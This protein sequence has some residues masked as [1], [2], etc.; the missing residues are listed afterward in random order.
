MV[1]LVKHHPWNHLSETELE[2][3]SGFRTTR[4]AKPPL[5]IG[6]EMQLNTL[7]VLAIAM[8]ALFGVLAGSHKHDDI[9][10]SE[11]IL[12]ELRGVQINCA[13]LQRDR[14]RGRAEMVRDLRA[15][16]ITREA[17][18]K[19]LTV[20]QHLFERAPHDNAENLSRLFKQLKE[21]VE[22]TNLE[23]S[24]SA[25]HIA[26]LQDSLSSFVRSVATLPWT[27]SDRLK[28][29]TLVLQF[30]A[31]PSASLASQI[32]QYLTRLSPSENLDSRQVFRTGRIVLS[33]LPRLA[34]S[35]S[36][37]AS[38]D[39]IAKATELEQEY[40]KSYSL[41]GANVQRTRVICA[42]VCL[43]LG[44][45]GFV[46]AHRCRT[47]TN[48]LTRR[49]E[50]EAA[51][52]EIEA[53]FGS[54]RATKA[55]VNSSTE[56]ALR[57]IQRVFNADQC[58]LAVVSAR[59]K[60][61]DSECFV[62]NT[63]MPVSN[64][65][66]IDLAA[67]LIDPEEPAFRVVSAQQVLQAGI[68][69]V[70]QI[71][72]CKVYDEQIAVCCLVYEE[73]RQLPVA[74]ELQ[75]L[76]RVTVSVCNHL[77]LQRMRSESE[78]VARRL[79]HAERLRSVGTIASGIAHEFNNIL[80][81]ILGYAEMAQSL[82]RRP[83]KPRSYISQIILA[84]NRA[85]LM[86]EQIL[87][88]SRERKRSTRPFDV[89][90]VVLDLVPL[91]RVT[92]GAEFQLEVKIREWQTVIE[93]SP[94]DIH[95]ILLN[96]CKNSS[97]AFSNGGRIEIALSTAHFHQ[98]KTL[99]QGILTPGR[100]VVLSISDDGQ[101]IEAAVLPHIFKPFFTTRS[102]AGGTGLGLAAVLR[103]VD[104]LGG[105]LNVTSTIGQGTRFDIY[106]PASDKESV[107]VDSSLNPFHGA[108]GNGE[109]VAVVAG[110][111]ATLEAYEDKIAAL[112][113][114]PMGFRSVESLAGWISCGNAPDLV[115]VDESVAGRLPMEVKRPAPKSVPV[116]IV[117]R[118]DC[119]VPLTC[120]DRAFVLWLGE[121]VSY[122]KLAYA[123]SAMVR[124]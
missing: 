122:S 43:C 13:L 116:I 80:A 53:C 27:A 3:R 23:I 85:R 52:S 40:L 47:Q 63:R 108:P 103:D 101:G 107:T 8:V 50:L 86:I 35:A 25:T 19:D 64:A 100:Y 89:S 120:D 65:A 77:D 45:I 105:R 1:F 115:I 119:P 117:G 2:F 31:K 90:D 94:T 18:Q 28:L 16:G 60:R 93:G 112:G 72:G 109:V 62:A 51:A 11:A 111:A 10:T 42:W 58:A 7:I 121:R 88:L 110:R 21:S 46:L 123:I 55:S 99:A 20:L 54:D 66:L 104:A 75:I 102:H 74:D 84:G 113:Y 26:L 78:N 92:L 56:A 29:S 61:G 114:A 97:E 124:A 57:V 96:L 76:S 39:A 17:L 41:I 30:S 68:P 12:R 87:S 22:R 15:V 81:A 118:S 38:F 71:L 83:S 49:L 33:V 59:N 6:R 32:D 106:L 48:R 9:Q 44:L 5:R 70:C 36:R 95:R 73:H 34:V 4:G 14:F 79:E 69:G 37:I 24:A 91:L 67:S 98:A 82:L